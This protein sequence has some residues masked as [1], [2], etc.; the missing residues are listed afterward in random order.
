MSGDEPSATV[1]MTGDEFLQMIQPDLDKINLLVKKAE[2]QNTVEE[3][4]F[5]AAVK[6]VQFLRTFEEGM[7]EGPLRESVTGLIATF[8]RVSKG[9]NFN[10]Q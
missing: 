8:D 10:K 5:F 1:S 7:P 3:D 4:D 9:F 6:S 2:S